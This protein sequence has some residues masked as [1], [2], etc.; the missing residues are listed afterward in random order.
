MDLKGCL[1]DIIDQ[2]QLW[3][4]PYE[5][6]RSDYISYPGKIDKNLYYVLDGS[7]RVFFERGEEEFTLRLGYRGS[8]ITALDSFITSN[9]SELYIQALRKL[10]V[11]HVEKERLMN[12]LY[13]DQRKQE[14]W[15]QMQ[16]MLIFQQ[17]EREKDLLID[18]PRERFK[19]V[20]ERS[21]EVF[22]QVPHKYIASYLRM[23]PETLSRL[24]K[25]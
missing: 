24:Q 14:L 6:K 22:Q 17:F 21:P 18:S 11:R 5:L 16:Q 2:A 20:L 15:M 9:P 3:S 1:I 7:L 19:K 23:T 25:S 13:S 8:F 10:Q 4:D 12:H